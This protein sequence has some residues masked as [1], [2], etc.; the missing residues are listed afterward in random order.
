MVG[1]EDARDARVEVVEVEFFGDPLVR[2][3]NCLEVQSD[4]LQGLH[5]VVDFIQVRFLEE[6]LHEDVQQLLVR[7]QLRRA[8][9]EVWA[10]L[11]DLVALHLAQEGAQEVAVVWEVLP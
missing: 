7:H 9:H 8:Q 4:D 1:L 2:V 6:Q 11:D 5:H 10:V 3:R